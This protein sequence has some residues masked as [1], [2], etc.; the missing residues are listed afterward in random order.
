MTPE[1]TTRVGQFLQVLQQ[2]EDDFA[3]VQKELGLT[4][5]APLVGL[6][7]ERPVRT[8]VAKP[9]RPKVEKAAYKT[10]R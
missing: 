7:A 4:G 8:A 10:T 6:G 1:P 9:A 2:A 5:S 3:T